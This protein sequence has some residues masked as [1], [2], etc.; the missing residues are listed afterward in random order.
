MTLAPAQDV[1]VG[2]AAFALG[3][4]AN[5]YARRT[6]QVAI[7]GILA[8]IFWLV[9]GSTGVRGA[10]AAFQKDDASTSGGAGFGL[11]MIVRAMAIAVGL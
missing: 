6:N 2:F 3:I 5:I 11:D 10:I 9:P 8:G 7:G 4:A 1:T